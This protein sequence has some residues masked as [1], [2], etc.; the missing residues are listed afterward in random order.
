MLASNHAVLRSRLKN[1]FHFSRAR[2]R[3]KKCW[4][5][6]LED[7]VQD[8]HGGM[9]GPNQMDQGR[10]GQLGAPSQGRSQQIRGSQSHDRSAQQTEIASG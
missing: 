3:V 9:A 5:E 6:W 10:L 7:I 1:R 2:F 8:G 4:L